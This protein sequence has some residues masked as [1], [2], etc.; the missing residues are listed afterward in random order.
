[1]TRFLTLLGKLVAPLARRD[2]PRLA[3]SVMALT[4][5]AAAL[6][7]S[8]AVLMA[9]RGLVAVRPEA[10][11]GGTPAVVGL[12]AVVTVAAALLAMAGKAGLVVF[13]VLT[14]CAACADLAARYRAVSRLV[15]ARP[16]MRQVPRG[17]P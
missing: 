14:P 4:G 5:S 9:G 7:A 6:T 11:T 16:V 8:S 3:L 15:A 13:A 12:L 17:G 1:M 10:G 2:L